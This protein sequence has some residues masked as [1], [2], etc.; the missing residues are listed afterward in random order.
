[1]KVL[2]LNTKLL[3][4]KPKYRILPQT[5]TQS[6]NFRLFI[7]SK[8]LDRFRT[9]QRENL[10][11]IFSHIS[12]SPQKEWPPKWLL[13]GNL[14]G[15]QSFPC[16]RPTTEN[17]Y[18]L[19]VIFFAPFRTASPLAVRSILFSSG[20]SK[21]HLSYSVLRG[22]IIYLE[23][24]TQSKILLGNVFQNSSMKKKRTE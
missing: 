22:G 8:S 12:Q 10:F 7:D 18:H 4:P 21:N 20:D 1:M 6:T 2:K 3:S 16:L 23:Q 13:E 5:T 15:G 24:N 19:D 9:L 14:P 11:I 17:W